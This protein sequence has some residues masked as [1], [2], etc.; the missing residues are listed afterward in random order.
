MIILFSI[1][2][3]IVIT[4]YIKKTKEGYESTYKYTAVIIEPREHPALEF[5]LQ[6]FNDNLSD[7]WQFLVFHGNQNK[8]YTEKICKKI[9]KPERVKLQ[10]LNVDN[11]T[12][13][14]HNQL[15]YTTSFWESI[16]T[17]IMLFFQ[18]DSII[19]SKDKDVI[20]DFLKYDYV[21]SPLQD[22]GQVGGGGLSIRRKSKLIEILNKCQNKNGPEDR[23]FSGN[24]EGISLYKPSF[25]EAK[26]FCVETVMNDTS[27]GVHKPYRYLSAN[28]IESIGG[29]CPDINKLIELNS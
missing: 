21:G 19:C 15:L 29:W 28:D 20:N 9:F 6:N 18:T 17:E 23:Y 26:K 1:L 24:C 8:E 13:E 11:F 22:S 7:E 25:E 2:L 5:V 3:L 10:N 4:F 16:P 14:E 12:N 27:F